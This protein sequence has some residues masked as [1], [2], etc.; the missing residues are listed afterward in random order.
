MSMVTGSDV[1]DEIETA[2][3]EIAIARDYA[4]AP[5]V[6]SSDAADT[7]SSRDEGQLRANLPRIEGG[8]A[9]VR[10]GVLKA[11]GLAGEVARAIA[12]FQDPDATEITV[13][14]GNLARSVAE[15]AC[16]LKLA[17]VLEKEPDELSVEEGFICGQG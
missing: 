15:R 12:L 14:Q 10:D 3:S 4:A 5:L 8:W 11:S 6:F 17:E 7:L 2:K 1:T 16:K 9:T 13:E